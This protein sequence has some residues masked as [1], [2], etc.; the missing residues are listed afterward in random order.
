MNMLEYQAKSLLGRHELP[1]PTSWLVRK[2]TS[3]PIGIVY[4]VVAKSQVPV[5]GRGKVGGIVSVHSADELDSVLKTIFSLSIKGHLPTAILLE[6]KLTVSRELY[7]ALRLNRD[8]RM[9]EWMASL[10]GGVDIEDN[11]DSI[12]TLPYD[13]PDVKARLATTLLV[14][15]SQ[16]T[17][18]IEQ[19]SDCFQGSDLTL[20]EINPLMV[21]NDG[22]LICADAKCIVDDNARFRQPNLPWPTETT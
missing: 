14:D 13:S 8:K 11:V 3:I 16:I 2:P 10:T 1:V 21:T 4:P 19:M 6:E 22:R 7:L 18:L 15:E 20:L 5:G 9:I 17:P 12:V